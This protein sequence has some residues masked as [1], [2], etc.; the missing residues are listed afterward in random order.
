MKAWIL[1]A[2]LVGTTMTP[3]FADH[4]TD[5]RSRREAAHQLL[6]EASQLTHD[7][8]AQASISAALKELDALRYKNASAKV[9]AIL[10]RRK[11]RGKKSPFLLKLQGAKEHLHWLETYKPKLS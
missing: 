3:L 11:F 6:S 5:L 10:Q 7:K 9:T 8:Q 1:A 2:L 4:S